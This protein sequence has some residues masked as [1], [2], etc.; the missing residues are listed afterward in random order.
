MGPFRFRQRVNLPD[1]ARRLRL[2]SDTPSLALDGLVAGVD[3]VRHDVF[4]TPQFTGVASAVLMRLLAR[5]ANVEDIIA[6]PK[7]VKPSGV[8]PEPPPKQPD[9]SD[10]K[11]ALAALHLAAIERAKNEGNPSLDLLAR[12]AVLKFLRS[13]TQVQFN[14][15]LERCRAR[16]KFLENQRKQNLPKT[17]ET[18]ERT[19]AL[20]TSKRAILRKVTQELLQTYRD[21]EKDSLGRLRR[22]LLGEDNPAYEIL[23]S[24]FAFGDDVRDE[25]LNAENYVMLGNF[26]RDPDRFGP[27]RGLVM[28]LFD[29]LGIEP[30]D[31]LL[32]APGNAEE[33]TGSSAEDSEERAQARRAILEAWTAMME[34]SEIMQP[35]L[36][37]YH[38]VPLIAEYSPPMHPQQLK[39]ALIS[40]EERKRVEALIEQHPRLSPENLQFAADKV[41]RCRGAE[42][43]HFA[44]RFLRDLF[45]YHRDVRR[46]EALNGALDMVNLVGAE[47]VRELSS[48]NRTLYEFLLGDEQP[49]Q[50][51]SILYHVIVKADIRGSTTLVTELSNRGLNP[52]SYFSLNFFDPVNKLLPKYDAQKLFIEGDALILAL[53]A[54]EGDVPTAVGRACA[55]AREIIDIVGAHNQKSNKGELPDLELGIG[56][57]C[58]E[59]AP[60]YLLDGETKIMISRALNHADRLAS[61]SRSARKFFEHIE[62]LFNVYCFYGLPN[63][64]E[65]AQSGTGNPPQ[66]A[67]CQAEGIPEEAFLRY[68]VAGAQLEEEA[69]EHL[70]CELSLELHELE[71]PALWDEKPVRLHCGV[72]PLGSGVFQ[73]LIVRESRVPRVDPASLELSAWTEKKYFEVCTSAEIYDYIEARSRVFAVAAGGE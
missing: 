66:P 63:R 11:S 73:R 57:S 65:I 34:A 64:T 72:V 32:N 44:A 36:A 60:M 9:A 17:F 54:R 38:V 16:L 70:S 10:F 43:A 33:L 53:F 4:L 39:N 45:R 35:V 1:C 68:N 18:R 13:E 61:C 12:L 23:I 8:R 15:L 28:Q 48:I 55:L 21:L 56:I 25:V 31:S 30:D 3:N 7:Y 50:G 62:S 26:E 49:A 47:N 6:E 41:S 29:N 58:Q 20:Q 67:E 40:K 5:F 2:A 22:S 69:F 59:G 51:E 37:A 27:V 71:L 52:A 14:N 24:R 19:G 42:R 46:L